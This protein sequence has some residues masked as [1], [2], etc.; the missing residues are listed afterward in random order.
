VGLFRGEPG[1]ELNGGA[2]EAERYRAE[3]MHHQLWRYYP[4]MQKLAERPRHP[5]LL[6]LWGIA[7]T[8]AK[9]RQLSKSAVER[10][11]KQHPIRRVDAETVLRTLQE[12]AIKVA[13]GVTEAASIHIRSLIAR[14]GVVNRELREAER[15]LDELCTAISEVDTTS[16]ESLQRRDVVILKSMPRIGRI[17]LAALLSEGFW[18][19]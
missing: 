13:D 11:L 8:P 12:W 10:I 3:T 2:C 1:K 14:L 4:Q 18:A 5:W 6:E 9:A 16:G 15:K 7:P 19:S 17:N